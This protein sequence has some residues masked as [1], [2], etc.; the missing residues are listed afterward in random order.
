MRGKLLA[1]ISI[2]IVIIVGLTGLVSA[3]LLGVNPGF[4]QILF[5]QPLP[6]ALTYDPVAQKFVINSVP[7]AASFHP[8]DNQPFTP[9]GTDSSPTLSISILV[10]SSGN[11][12]GV[13]TS[14]DLVIRG[15]VTD[16]GTLITY[17]GDL[18]TG[19]VTGFGYL[20]QA[21]GQS[22]FD[23]TFSVT[24]GSMASFYPT[25]NQIGVT[26]DSE[27]STF[28][29]S[30]ALPFNGAAK[31]DVGPV[32]NP[33]TNT[34]CGGSIGDFVWN[35]VNGNGIQDSGEPGIDGVTV[36]LLLNGNVIATTVTGPFGANQHGYYQFTGICQGNYTVAVDTTTIPAGFVATITNA[37]N[38]TAVDSNP[39]PSPVTLP[40]N[41]SSDETIDF[42]FHSPCTGSIGDFVWSDLN[43]NGLQDAGEPGIA[44]VTVTLFDSTGLIQLATTTTGSLGNYSFGGLCAGTYTVVVAPPAGMSPTTPTVGSDTTIDSNG[45][46]ATVTLPT[47]NSTDITIDFGFISPWTGA[48]GDYV[49][50][51]ANQNGIQDANEVGI[52][53][54]AV[55]LKDSSGNL[56]ATAIT[57]NTSGNHGYYQFTGLGAGTY[58]VQ[59]VAG[60]VPPQYVAPTI[61][62]APGST[63]AN[64][65]N[66]Q[67]AIVVLSTNSSV[68]ETIDFGY[69]AN[70]T[71][72]IG[73]F[74]WNDLNDN[75]IQDTGEPG[76]DGV[77]VYLRNPVNNA[78]L[79]TTVT[80]NG[81]AYTFGGLC[82]G[83]YQVQVVTPA[84]YTPTIVNAPG[85]TTANDSNPN[86]W[87]VTLTE[88]NS[89]D[90]TVDFG[91]LLLP[92]LT[93]N[94]VTVPSGDTTTFNLQINGTTI[95]SGGD[96]T[97]TGAQT[98]AVGSY[99]VGETGSNLT[100]YS[101]VISGECDVNGNITLVYG[102]NAVCTITNTK[103]SYLNVTKV[104][105]PAGDS[106]V[107]PIMA[108]VATG[109]T[110]TVISNPA[111]NI[112]SGN[113]F[114]YQVTAGTYTVTETV[115]SGWSQTSTTCTGVVVTAGQNAS[116]TITNTK[117]STLTVNKVTVPGSD[118]TVFPI[119]ASST[120][121][122]TI[123]G[124]STGNLSTST[125]V[126]FAV[127]AGTYSIAETLPTG[128][129]QNADGGCQNVVVAAGD[130]K[131]CTITNTRQPAHIIVTKVTN[132]ASDPT[133]FSIV[134]SSSTGGI[135][136]GNATQGVTTSVPVNYS[137]TPG[138]Y[139]VA[140]TV[141]TGWT[142]T[143]N[144][145]TSANLV[146]TAGQ[147][148]NCTITNTKLAA[149]G[150]FVW[151]DVNANGIQDAGEPG[152]PGVTV[153]LLQGSTTVGTAVTDA[154][155]LYHFINLIPGNYVVQFTAPT[156]FTPSPQMV[157]GNPA[158][159]SNPNAA[160]TTPTVTLAAGQ[161]DNTID[162][163]FYSNCMSG[164]GS[165][166]ATWNFLSP[167]GTLGTSQTYTVNG[168]TI[169]AYGYTNAGVPYALYGKNSGADEMGLGL[170][171][172]SDDEIDSAHFVQLDLANVISSGAPGVQLSIGS[173][174]SGEGYNVYGSNTL[175][176]LGTLLIGNSSLDSALFNVPNFP[177]Y[178][179][180]SIQATT[181][182][183]VI[184]ALT[185][186]MASCTATTLAVTKITVPSTDTGKFNLLING[187]A[188]AT[189][190]GNG[191]T[192]GVQ[193][194]TVGSNTFG[195]TAGTGSVLTD[196]TAVI[197]GQGCT[198][199]GNGT[200]SI[201]LS[202]GNNAVCLI[203]NTRKPKLTITKVT[204]PSTDTGKFNLLINGTADATNISNGG[205]TGAQYAK[206]GSNTFGETP[207][208][209]TSLASYTSV[210]TG[211]G[212]IDNG[213]GTGTITMAAGDNVTCTIT[214]TQMT[215]S[216]LIVKKVTVPSPDTTNTQ[217]SVT[218]GGSGQCND[219]TT[220]TVT[221]QTPADFQVQPGTYSA[222]ETVP[223]G[224]TQTGN[225]CTNVVVAAGQTVSCTITNTKNSQL[226]VNKVTIPSPDA[227]AFPVTINVSS[228][229][230]NDS[231]TKSVTSSTPV[232]FQVS[233]GTYSVTETVP[234][235]W[236]QTGN[237]CTNVVV[238]SGV[239]PSC[240]ITNT[241]LAAVGDFVWNDMNA[242][243]IQ[244]SGE[245]GIAGVTVTLLQGTTVIAT[246]TT[247][248]S[249]YYSFTNL[250]PGTYTEQ[251]S[252][253][254][255]FI[256]SPQFKGTNTA[257][258]SNINSSGLT[259]AF[260]L[261]AGQTDNTIDAGF[262]K[263]CQGSNG[264]STAVWNFLNPLGQL[265]STQ[266]YTVNGITITAHG[267]YNNGSATNLYAK[268][269]GG[270]ET[271]LGL[272][273]ENDHEVDTNGFIQL[274]LQNVIASGA[275][276]V[277]LSIG[278]VQ[279]G[280]KYNVYGSNT[281]GSIG[282]LLIS[283][284]TKDSTLFTVPS[285]PNYRYIAIRA[286]SG[287]VVL[288]SLSIPV[289]GC[290]S[291]S[292]TITKVVVP[293]TDS[294]LFNLS[295]N[296][297]VYASNVGNGGTTGTQFGSV[298]S[299]S[300]GETA[301]NSTT[302]S[303][304]TAVITGTGC[305]DNGNGTGSINLS[306]G[307]NLTCTITNTRKGHL[308]V[309][310]VTSPSN[311]PTVFSVSLSGTGQCT[312]STT[313]NFSSSTPAN[314][315]LTPGTYSIT[316]TVPL[317]WTK[318]SDTC[319]GVVIAAGQ[320]KSC[321]ITNTKST[322][323]TGYTC[324]TQGGWG[325]TP[326]GGNPGQVLKTN[327]YKV[328]S[329]GSVYV[330]GSKTSTW[331]SSSNIE[332]FLPQGGTPG[333][334]S[335][336]HTNPTN[337][338]AGVFAGEVLSLRLNVDFSNA[339]ITKTGLANLHLATGPLAGSTVAQVL[340]IAQ[341]VLGGGALPSGMSL[342][343]LNNVCD[344]INNNFDNGTV[345]NGY[346]Y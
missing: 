116:C 269:E 319:Q 321:T 122:G 293:S 165:G 188:K 337:T 329:G 50:Y 105:L 97:T 299:N 91:F 12:T 345:N 271:G 341:S 251:F 123:T 38:N 276:S 35:D 118:P 62:N 287:D 27:L 242:N 22:A 121:G 212:C 96:G 205:T 37:G 253:P 119:T 4:P 24:G 158:V 325:S 129:T 67:P 279:S 236:K 222:T 239:S 33:N 134:A 76:I 9:A 79:A 25:G 115:P 278:S 246:T 86:N 261:A 98:E 234:V 170:N 326:N 18:L 160:G 194:A 106:T 74:V 1:V 316:E 315:D 193:S 200:G 29:G 5:N 104:T 262:Y 20:N 303:N 52:D 201:T 10:D 64:D 223:S 47:N 274:D 147:T 163:G 2:V 249:G 183:V 166:S 197:S 324:Y 126:T 108:G 172:L 330:G 161:T 49:W 248:S 185:I 13:P 82:P 328:Y 39:N 288:I 124:S 206:I 233:T 339:G 145:C 229:K 327:Y 217:F 215:T 180:V 304:Y 275:S 265:G 36:N 94:K 237:T 103:N 28:T 320:T 144:T 202:S 93:V 26:V 81:G 314:Y 308:T 309:Y 323:P 101:G 224:W 130:N 208:T 258:D 228:G 114:P 113:P 230:C 295:I 263:N 220:K 83:S 107:F 128:W 154:N 284:S 85:S 301:G 167:L 254:A 99:I 69:I 216:H 111:E 187:P 184:A 66:V 90:N 195:E 75:G 102:Q 51:D 89:S 322:K 252:I 127:S 235:G 133:S 232:G 140:E 331:T 8:F 30:F 178:R 77:T 72:S 164:G 95:I 175:G 302:L 318:T 31:G 63:T 132:P 16:A 213:N 343:D 48:I 142:L 192:T 305:T 162:A 282:T 54:V 255:G 40:N 346:L 174:Q 199:N 336:N 286:T 294:G 100:A 209:S 19:T 204:V 335:S 270:D 117:A 338:E 296:S 297:T 334:F 84:G 247:T 332:G 80:A 139:S 259:A 190:I 3:T 342:S 169:T 290:T 131:S 141:P 159:D 245:P 70:C 60:T 281:L 7:V 179:Y 176:S 182:N 196:Y 292:L 300:F 143:S 73:D 112:S 238:S 203:T 21:P 306:A 57:N 125:P 109:G 173:V 267:Y 268:N 227:T 17:T 211:T 136:T 250:L 59:V 135:I 156:G 311:D 45:S 312:Q 92:T 88:D 240:T 148:A 256:A 277:S 42:G 214:N 87:T 257:V 333:S 46:P 146:L 155:G 138:T 244:D 317:G 198:D 56:L 6:T 65:S 186:P 289:G 71:G 149:L 55:T 344:A 340:A 241:K 273:Y 137:V 110:G 285:Y 283:N 43:H 189:N 226:I 218:V 310:K 61:S 264:S 120:T 307:Q 32:P 191:G 152:I 221:W 231:T 153:T 280:E 23:F 15:T 207:G 68:D 157:G 177:T 225:T 313:Q 168:I 266:A 150:D 14:R 219:G 181:G 210:I 44:G 78:I 34:S 11:L 291:T 298:G 53:G 58:T 272:A 41:L 151:N 243:G 260:T 171:A